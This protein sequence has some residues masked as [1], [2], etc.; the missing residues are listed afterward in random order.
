MLEIFCWTLKCILAYVTLIVWMM[1]RKSTENYK[2]Q[3]RTMISR[4][5]ICYCCIHK[6]SSAL[7]N[8]CLWILTTLENLSYMACCYTILAKKPSMARILIVFVACCGAW[9]NENL[10]CVLALLTNTAVQHNDLQLLEKSFVGLGKDRLF[11]NYHTIY[12]TSCVSLLHACLQLFQTFKSYMD[13]FFL[14]IFTNKKKKL[15]VD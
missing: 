13:T 4:V 8:K 6:W 15:C 10:S 3:L 9:M 7:H 5:I 2:Q 12:C 1:C 14:H 11:P